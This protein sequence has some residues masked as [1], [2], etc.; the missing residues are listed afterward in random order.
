MVAL[1]TEAAAREA[2]GGLSKSTRPVS[3]APSAW[4]ASSWLQVAASILTPRR[5]VRMRSQLRG[6]VWPPVI[7]PQVCRR[8]SSSLVGASHPKGRSR[9]SSSPK[10]GGPPEGLKPSAS[11]RN[12]AVEIRF[13]LC[14]IN[15]SPIQLRTQMASIAPS[16]VAMAQMLAVG[17]AA[18]SRR[19]RAEGAGAARVVH[20]TAVGGEVPARRPA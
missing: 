6:R 7:K 12:V 1:K 2:E 9:G 5:N 8:S 14:A 17:E 11:A 19:L 4:G 16:Q 18:R 3:A 15:R 13:A 20:V 10:G